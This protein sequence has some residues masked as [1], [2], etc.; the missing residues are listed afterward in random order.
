MRKKVLDDGTV[1]FTGGFANFSV[2]LDGFLWW[3]CGDLCGK[4]GG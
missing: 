4:R 1:V 2:F 3:S